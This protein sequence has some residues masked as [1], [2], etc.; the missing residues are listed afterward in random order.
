MLPENIRKI[1]EKQ[2]ELLS[3]DSMNHQGD[4]LATISMAMVSVAEMLRK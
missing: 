3:K 1:L 2:L 4:T